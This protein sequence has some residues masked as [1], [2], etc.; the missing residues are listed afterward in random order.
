MQM[1]HG[2]ELATGDILFFLHADVRPPSDFLV[3]IEQALDDGFDAGIFS[4]RFDSDSKILQFNSYFTRFD[5]FYAGGGDQGLFIK[6]EVFE[7]LGQFDDHWVIM[8]D[9]D[10]FRKLKKHKVPYTIIQ[11]PMTV[12]ARKYKENS[13]FKVNLINLIA[14]IRFK[15]GSKPE[16]IRRFYRKWIKA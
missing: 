14:V 12:S 8:E 16:D 9:F 13:W 6:S 4:Y 10:F 3:Q 2:A 5:G 7:R 15:T 1:N 11:S